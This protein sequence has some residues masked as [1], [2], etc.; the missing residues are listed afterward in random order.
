MDFDAGFLLMGH[1]GP[2]NVNAADERAKLQHVEVRDGKT[3]H[4]L[5]IDFRIQ[6]CPVTLAILTQFNAGK[7]FRLI[8]TVAEA[9][10]GG[11]SQ[12]Q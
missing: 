10:P 8:S 3:G 2:N 5:G 1:D 4:D 11:S 12:Y 6:Q 9:I 7:T